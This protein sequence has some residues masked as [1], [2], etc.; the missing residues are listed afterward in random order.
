MDIQPYYINKTSDTSAD[1]LQAIGFA[2]LLSHILR[3]LGRPSKGLTIE[4]AGPYFEVRPPTSIS[5]SDLQHLK[6]F[7][8]L[9]L[10]V[11][12]TQIKKQAGKQGKQLDG[13]YY[14]TEQEK[15]RVYYAKLKTLEAVLRTPEARLNRSKYPILGELEEPDPQL[16]H[17][18]AINQMKIASSFNDLLQR[19]ADLEELQ[20]EH[21]R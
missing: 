6:P 21:I 7:S 13:F 18:R 20:R 9:R 11:T 19:W 17:Y 3:S 10:L 2:S 8:P 1:T 15:S 16:G 12:A 5:D 14:E 4:D